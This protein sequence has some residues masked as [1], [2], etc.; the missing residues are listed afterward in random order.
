MTRKNSHWIALIRIDS[1]RLAKSHTIMHTSHLI[2]NI[3]HRCE[4]PRVSVSHIYNLNVFE[5]PSR[6]RIHIQWISETNDERSTVFDLYNFKAKIFDKFE[7]RSIDWIYFFQLLH[8]HSF[9]FR[10]RDS[11]L[12]TESRIDSYIC[13]EI[14]KSYWDSYWF[15][16]FTG[17]LARMT[18]QISP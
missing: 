16:Y 13:T 17:R 14:R 15:V 6:I 3:W 18:W 8:W 2:Q 7:N 11:Q 12:C 5:C 1:P 10:H 4:S 9:E